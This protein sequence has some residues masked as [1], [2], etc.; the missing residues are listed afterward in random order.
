M[1]GAGARSRPAAQAALG[2]ACISPMAILV[3]LANDG[4]VPTVVY[5][6]CLALPVL[7]VLAVA[8]RRRRGPRPAASRARALLAGLFLAADLVLFN[9]TIT[10][11]GA[12][13]ATVTG[14]LNVPFVAVL[15]W[16][17]LGERPGRRYL[18]VLPVVLTGVVLV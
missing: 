7:A 13:I 5:R 6:C 17:V 11:L 10:D 1:P 9:N 2:A 15:A 3:A 4:P 8:E 16:I 12:G 14:S 18:V